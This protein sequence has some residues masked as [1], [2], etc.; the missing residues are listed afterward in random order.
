[1]IASIALL[2]ALGSPLPSAPPTPQQLSTI[3]VQAPHATLTL[4]VAK[5]DEQRERGLMSVTKLTPHTGML[6]VF[7]K[8]APV[9]FWMKDTLVPLDMVFAGPDGVVRSVA[10]NVPATKPDTPD[11]KIPR[12]SANAKYVIELPA[13]EAEKDGITGAVHLDL[14]AADGHL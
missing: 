2:F 4:Q 14:T 13:G 7:D 5:T 9:E 11:E 12:R 3:T 1:M 10:A 8:D 6:F